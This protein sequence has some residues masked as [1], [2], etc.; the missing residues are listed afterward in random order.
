MLKMEIAIDFSNYL[1]FKFEVL[2][3]IHFWLMP[4][5]ISNLNRYTLY[6]SGWLVIILSV[7]KLY[8]Y[9]I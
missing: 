3:K 6:M 2:F 7:D 1:K 9:N 5:W 8:E 4:K